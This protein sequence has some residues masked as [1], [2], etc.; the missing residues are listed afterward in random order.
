MASTSLHYRGLRWNRVFWSF[1][2]IPFCSVFHGVLCF[3]DFV[4]GALLSERFLS[5]DLSSKMTFFK[6]HGS[7]TR[8]G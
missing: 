4:A 7:A 1:A 5:L 6:Y 3:V 2:S 8:I